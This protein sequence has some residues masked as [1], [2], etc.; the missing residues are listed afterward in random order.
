MAP[1]ASA[2]LRARADPQRP[3]L[4]ELIAGRIALTVESLWLREVDQHRQAWMAYLAE[5]S[6][7]LGQSLTST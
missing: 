2:R 5:A 6:E 1:R 4:T 3:D 7:L